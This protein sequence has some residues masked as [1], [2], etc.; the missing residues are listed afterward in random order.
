MDGLEDYEPSEYVLRMIV[1]QINLGRPTQGYALGS[2][3]KHLF[4]GGVCYDSNVSA[5]QVRLKNRGVK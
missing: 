5:G 2:V 4:E 1:A 3:I